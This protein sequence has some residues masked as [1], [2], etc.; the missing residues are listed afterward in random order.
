MLS[1][2]FFTA[3]PLRLRLMTYRAI[4]VTACLDAEITTSP[5]VPLAKPD[6]G[7][8]LDRNAPCLRSISRARMFYALGYRVPVSVFPL[9]ARTINHI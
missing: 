4:T 7:R 9:T 1:L 3:R 6:E 8:A 2:V 5:L